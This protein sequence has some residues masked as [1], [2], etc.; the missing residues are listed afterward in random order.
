[1]SHALRIIPDVYAMQI[2]RYRDRVYACVVCATSKDYPEAMARTIVRGSSITREDDDR[3]A[4]TVL[5]GMKPYLELFPTGDDPVGRH[6]LINNAPFLVVGVFAVKGSKMD[7]RDREDDLA[8]IPIKTGEARI[9]RNQS[10]T[11]I[12]VEV[13]DFKNVDL[14]QDEIRRRFMILHQVEDF[15]IYNQAAQLE[16]AK[17]E[18][19]LLQ[20]L[21]ASAALVTLVVGGAGVMNIMLVNVVERTR[22]IGVRMA[23][24]ARARDIQ[25]QFLT[26]AV[27]IC[28]IGGLL[29]VALGVGVAHRIT[30]WDSKAVVT[31]LPVLLS[32]G[33]AFATGI[34]F[35]F[36]PA[37]KASLLDPVVALSSE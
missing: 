33:A 37:R 31:I 6:I 27:V 36:W 19:D 8:I 16:A 29:G 32:L 26:E 35:G 14:V 5:L 18:L 21:L 34:L 3:R 9:L 22:E 25:L 2:L 30:V 7:G 12:R 11:E 1:M 15:H 23:C 24:G 28:L 10:L 4:P 17:H 20:F 13:D